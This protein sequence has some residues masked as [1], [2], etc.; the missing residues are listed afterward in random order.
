MSRPRLNDEQRAAVEAL[1]CH[2]LLAAGAGSGKTRVLVERYLR[3]LEDGGWDPDLPA[4]LLAITFTEKAA[5]EMRERILRALL[6]RAADL[7]AGDPAAARLAALRREMEAAPISTIH[8]FCS[9]V[10]REN[11]VEAGL[12]PQFRVPS[13]LEQIRLEQS[14]LEALFA[15]A[16]PELARLV[17]ALGADPVADA[18]RSLGALRRSLGL[19]DA[20][21][22]EASLPALVAEHAKLGRLGLGRALVC[23]LTELPGR[24]DGLAGHVPGGEHW[25]EKGRAMIAAA[26]DLAAGLRVA[27]PDAAAIAAV[28]EPLKGLPQTAD[29][30]KD[31]RLAR[32]LKALRD[33]LAAAAA[34]AALIAAGPAGDA[35]PL[36]AAPGEEGAPAATIGDRSAPDSEAGAAR[37]RPAGLEMDFLRLLRRHQERLRAEKAQ[38]A[39]LD[40]EDLQLRAVALLESNDVVRERYHRQLRHVMVDEFQDTNLLQ[41]RLVRALVP[42]GTPPGRCCLFLV[43]D[44]RQ[45]IYAFRNADVDLF[46]GLHAKMAARD[47]TGNLRLNYRSHPDLLDFISHLFP[48]EE[49]PPLQA[50][51]ETIYAE[52]CLSAAPRVRV[53]AAPGGDGAAAGAE[54]AA[55]A[56]AAALR[57]AKEGGL[58]VLDLHE[59]SPRERPIGWGDMAVLL[60]AGTGAPA[61]TRALEEAGIPY[62]ASAGRETFLREELR[63]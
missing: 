61:V 10:L 40:F 37:A 52:H 36:A 55:R 18:L 33:D 38:R 29:G 1:E 62:T 4:R 51:L 7:G 24:V 42:P 46:R 31:E 26:R 49:F 8:G 5:Q 28:A 56:L 6:E 22:A 25:S 48:R 32:K 57:E 15:E 12:D 13:E 41:L 9:R 16:T 19:E 39:W 34:D 50:G 54:R 2:L 58:P 44:A 27:F 63:D 43:G 53:L 60:R 59:D 47:E 14:C 35:P 3:I 17:T 20:D 23:W 30:A 11:A 21:L 45:S